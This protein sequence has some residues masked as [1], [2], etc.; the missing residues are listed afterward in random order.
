MRKHI[1]ICERCG[2]QSNLKLSAHGYLYLR[3]ELPSNWNVYEDKEVCPKCSK[4]IDKAIKEA[5]K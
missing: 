3:Y 1:V 4:L 2:C 5:M